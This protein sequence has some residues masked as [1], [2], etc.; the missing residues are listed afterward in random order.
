MGSRLAGRNFVRV[1][2]FFQ[3]LKTALLCYVEEELRVSRGER[4]V[5]DKGILVATQMREIPGWDGKQPLTML[6]M[7]N[8]DWLEVALQSTTA[9]EL[10]RD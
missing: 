9:L 8:G 4:V 3:H 1:P 10:G 5:E 7:R 6:Q 2:P